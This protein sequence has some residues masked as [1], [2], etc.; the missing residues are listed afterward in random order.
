MKLCIWRSGAV[1][2]LVCAA[3]VCARADLIVI[4]FDNESL[5]GLP[6][7]TLQVTGTVTNTTADTLFTNSPT[8]ALS[9]FAP[10]DVD[11]SPMLSIPVPANGT[12]TGVLLFQV[13]IPQGFAPGLYSGTLTVLG[14]TNEDA[15]NLKL[16]EA[17][18]AVGVLAAVPEPASA[19]LLL[20]GIGMSLLRFRRR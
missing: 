11:A 20:S 19:V 9:G 13:A 12:L 16:T 8:V 7:T 4:S 14:G 18:F 6:G 17:N 1:L 5:R 2:L 10:E 3:A 15:D